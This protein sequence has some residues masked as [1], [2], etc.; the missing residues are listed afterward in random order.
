MKSPTASHYIQPASSGKRRSGGFA[1]VVT[2]ALM[3][4]LAIL[5]VGLLSLSSVSLRTAR[6]G[7]AQAEAQANARMAMML[8]IGELQKTMG[9]DRF[10]S[11]PAD[12]LGDPSASTPPRHYT[13][14]WTARENPRD[15][16]SADTLGK[17]AIYSSP[18]AFVRW[19]VSD[20]DNDLLAD[21]G[22]D[23]AARFQD[24]VDMVGDG[25]AEA[26]GHVKAGRVPISGG[27]GKYAW[28]VSENGTKA[29]LG[30][31]D[32]AM[33]EGQSR[34]EAL[35]SA[36]TPGPYGAEAITDLN[37]RANTDESD[38][39]ASLRTT[40]LM[41]GLDG[42]LVGSYRV[43]RHFHDVTPFSSSL[44]T[45]VTTGG[46]RKDLSLFFEGEPEAGSWA[47][48]IIGRNPPLGPYG[49]DSLSPRDRYDVG[50]WKILRQHYAMHKDASSASQIGGTIG[51]T[52]NAVDDVKP[53]TGNAHP[54]PSW[55]FQR[56]SLQPTLVRLSYLL[57]VGVQD[58]SMGRVTEANLKKITPVTKPYDKET[59]KYIA[60]FHAFPVVCIWNPYS[61]NLRIPGFSVGNMGMS[62]EHAVGISGGAT[63]EFQWLLHTGLTEPSGIFHVHGMNVD[64]PFTL[65]PGEVKMF[66]GTGDTYRVGSQNYTR[67]VVC[68]QA[69]DIAFDPSPGSPLTSAGMVKNG[70]TGT[71]YVP[72]DPNYKGWEVLDGLFGGIGDSITIDTNIYTPQGNTGTNS[73]AEYNGLLYYAT[74]SSMDVRMVSRSMGSW[75][76]NALWW[77]QW[78]G[79]SNR[80]RASKWTNKI[81]W[82]NDRGSPVIL[83]QPIRAV[84][85]IADLASGRKQPYMV[86]DLRLK[87]TGGDP[88]ERN[89]NI[90]WLH[91]I[92]GHG[93][94]GCSGQTVSGVEVPG[95][96]NFRTETHARP[97]TVVY[98]PVQSANEAWNTL[99]LDS[100]GGELRTFMGNSYRP[101]GQ[102]KA[103]A[104]EIPATP[105][106]SI[107]QLQHV[108]QV[109]TDAT[110]W[111][112]L[113]LQNY[114]IGN[115]YAN[116]NVP[117]DQI[118]TYG[119]NVWLDCRV[120]NADNRS[121]QLPDLD[122]KKWFVTV[123]GTG[124][125]TEHFKPT[126]HID[127]SYAANTLL[128]DDFF[129]SGMAGQSGRYYKGIGGAE[130]SLAEVVEGFL[131]D[132]E[133]LPNA[134]FAP[135]LLGKDPATAAASL[136][137]KGNYRKAAAHIGVIG[138]FNVNSTSKAAWKA[139]LASNLRKKTVTVS[140]SALPN[141]T[142]EESTSERY[143]I[144]RF[145]LANGEG[146]GSS[147]GS[148]EQWLGYRTVS[149]AD[150]DDLAEKIVEQAKLRG[151]FRS[152][153][154]F[155]NRRLE[156]NSDLALRGALQ[157]ALDLSPVNADFTA[158]PI[159]KSE[160]TG[161]DYAYED[162]ALLARAAGSP[163]YVMQGDLLQAVGS[164]IQV[165][166]DTFTIRA[167][168]ES[169][170][171]SAK[172]WC[173]AVV[174]RSPD[175]V[176][177]R[178]SAE[179]EPKDLLPV[180]QV[181]GRRLDIIS[182]R[183]L[184]P[185]EV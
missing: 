119:W 131:R 173:E 162:A 78:G 54:Y 165:R 71:T 175:W 167:Y 184:S 39:L 63:Q 28:W 24:P 70:V 72:D 179:K 93:F 59:N 68:A 69:T 66:V 97:Y 99:Q 172:A 51:E 74:Y 151:P 104:M 1:L 100:F 101:D 130:R 12:I 111:S 81:G 7:A 142:M 139:F 20:R 55:N 171:G 91:N 178:D 62:V 120:D 85:N 26:D 37:F 57:S 4:L 65:A 107:A 87:S 34:A 41:E 95:A 112:G 144:S 56:K 5:A 88:D 141:A 180:N 45:N 6:Q 145:S 40:A 80:E 159:R 13:G 90:V 60:T 129:F 138:G 122:G 118:D 127:R 109:P 163:P 30:A 168:G 157:A 110:R 123:N 149:D 174:Q 44:L 124:P 183:W 126:R 22:S 128:W 73:W 98:H 38:R 10:I 106:L 117:A 27:S 25:S 169:P 49:L 137:E 42:S 9:R 158:D 148:N 161:T 105:L 33:R 52:L 164:L 47:G 19:L 79:G 108:P 48:S 14:V 152:I 67:G 82:R 46:L 84:A 43:K 140:A 135:H 21:E 115:S 181:F 8:A 76:S 64:A 146:H 36:A 114:A 147:S 132:G 31:T 86:V 92:P 176:D 17:T 18:D 50:N 29:P 160:I 116:P 102:H 16:A 75:K 125:P 103:V 121:R 11:A 155:V 170:D 53:P 182:F 143:I 134:R 154:E 150:L 185:S 94:S 133:P 96:G 32:Q 15:D 61:Q 89:P 2:L 3:V 177:G 153:G 113:S 83:G 35:L 58:A 166:S 156:T 23:L 77:T 136:L